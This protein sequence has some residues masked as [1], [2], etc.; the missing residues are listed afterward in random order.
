MT[1][2]EPR[3]F[4]IGS[5]RSTNEPH[6]CPHNYDF[7]LVPEIEFYSNDASFENYIKNRQYPASFSLFF[8][9]YTNS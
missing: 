5:D 8:V 6:H 2:F 1:G 4:G 3:T 7:T 9:F